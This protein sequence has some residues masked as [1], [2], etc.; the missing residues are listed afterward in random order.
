MDFDTLWRCVKRVLK[1]RGVFLTTASEPFASLLRVSNLDWYK[2]DWVWDKGKATNHA[3]VS[4]SPLRL[5]EQ[6]LIFSV[7]NPTYFPQ[8]TKGK[9]Y[10]GTSRKISKGVW[11]ILKSKRKN[12]N[13]IRYPKSILHFPFEMWPLHPTQKPVALYEY[14]IRTYTQP[15]DVVLDP[16]A[17]SGTTGLAALKTGRQYILGDSDPGYVEAARKRIANAD[18]YV[19]SDKGNGVVQLSLFG[20]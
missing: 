3:N 20:D 9:P 4:K 5:H 14:L 10:K 16:F 7:T 1:P 18:P 13:G 8:L 19:S 11:N 2:Y 15:G 12:N 6:I 17:G